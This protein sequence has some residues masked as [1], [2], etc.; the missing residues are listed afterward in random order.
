MPQGS[1]L[2]TD[3][4]KFVD[5]AGN[6]YRLAAGSPCINTGWRQDWMK[7]DVDLD[8]RPRLDRFTRLADIGCYEYVFP[9][10]M[11]HMR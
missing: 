6:D 9:G 7:D 5:P 11:F 2:I 10:T 1:V 4:P 8:G 3:Y